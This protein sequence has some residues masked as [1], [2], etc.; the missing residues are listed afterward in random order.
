MSETTPMGRVLI[1]G[2]ASGLGAAVADAVA[3][4]GGTPIVLDRR[5]PERPSYE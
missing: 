3:E 5:L 4:A 2:G 1:T